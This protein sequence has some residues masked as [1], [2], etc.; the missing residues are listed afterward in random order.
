MDNKM[1]VQIVPD[2]SEVERV[3]ECINSLN[4][5]LEKANSL[6]NELASRN[7]IVISCRVDSGN[8]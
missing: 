2:L 1:Y 6:L 4:D 3:M 5:A 8:E 7:E